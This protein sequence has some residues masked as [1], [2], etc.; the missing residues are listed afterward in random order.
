MALITI[1]DLEEYLQIT[2]TGTDDEDKYTF[3]IG[4]VQDLAD[5]ITFRELESAT[6]TSELYDGNSGSELYLNQY[7]IT[8]VAEVKYGFVWGGSARSE[9]TS[10]DYLTYAAEGYLA[11]NFNSVDGGNQ[12]FEITYTA[13]YTTITI[14][15]DLKMLLMDQIAS[16]FNKTFN[17]PEMKSENL[18]DYSYTKFSIADMDDTSLFG[19]KL[20]K[21]IKSDL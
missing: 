18:G 1:A 16:S 7:P 3:L 10:D 11:F 14:P 6:Y 21:Y 12:I 20:S 9:I 4:A 17:S 19:Q 2:I 8:D 5:S 15:Q 13:G